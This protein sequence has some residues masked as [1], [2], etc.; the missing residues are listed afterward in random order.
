MNVLNELKV[1]PLNY[2]ADLESPIGVY[3]RRDIFKKEAKTD[4]TLKRKLYEKTVADQSADGSWEQLFVRTAN[5]L[6]D[7][8]L[9]GYDSEDRS[10]K[11][12]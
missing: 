4:T 10:I 1:N 7:L 2:V 9:L 5:N 8:A 3:L 6:W 12:G 11:K